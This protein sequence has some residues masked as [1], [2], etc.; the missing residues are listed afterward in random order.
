MNIKDVKV[1]QSV[2][3]ELTGNACRGKSGAELIEEWEV[4][5]VGRKLIKAKRKGWND[6]S[7]ITF[8]RR[9]FG[10]GDHFVEKTDYS[11]DYIMYANRK[12]LED[13]LERRD[14]LMFVR[15]YFGGYGEKNISVGALRKIANLIREEQSK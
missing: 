10:F 1:G 13:E 9:E 3:I 14:L 12:D 7:A 4:V 5:S 11:V 6:I 2:Y 15:N 8:E